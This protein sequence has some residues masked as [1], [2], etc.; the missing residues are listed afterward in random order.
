MHRTSSKGGFTLAELMV[1][2]AV[3]F[4]AGGV[5]YSVTRGLGYLSAKN[6]AINLT[7]AQARTTIHRAV[8]E[9]RDAVSIPQL[10]DANGASLGTSNGPAAGVSYQQLVGGPCLVATNAAAAQNQIRISSR[11][12]D[13]PA[14]VGMRLVIPA[15]FIE[16]DITA[17]STRSGTP[18][19][20]TLTIARNLTTAITAS[21]G[22]YVAYVTQRS[23]LLVAG[24]ELRYFPRKNA[25]AY[26]VVTRNITS[27]QPF[28]VQPGN[29]RFIQAAFSTEDPRILRRNFRSM[30]LQMNLTIPYRFR[31]TNYQ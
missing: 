16:E 13:P 8:S 22:T 10:V 20:Q 26:S 25:S 24:K 14:A 15:F 27:P 23:A 30:N 1:A 11:P 5:I 17:V 9:I 2:V 19:A 3:L 6:A 29:N 7:H 31:L 12:G 21:S 18:P 4:V 28:S